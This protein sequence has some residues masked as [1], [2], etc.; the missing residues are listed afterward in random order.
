MTAREWKGRIPPAPH[1]FFGFRALLGRPVFVSGSRVGLAC[2][3]GS[4]MYLAVVRG[5]R[6]GCVLVLLAR[7]GGRFLSSMDLALATDFL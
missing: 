3:V 4:A 6:F 7:H 2:E 5:F 1:V